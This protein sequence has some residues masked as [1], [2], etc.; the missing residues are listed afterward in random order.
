MKKTLKTDLSPSQ[1]SE[2]LQAIS[3]PARSVLQETM[4]LF[5][6]K[7]PYEGE[8]SPVDFRINRR[9]ERNA[10]FE[11]FELIG[12]I[13]P[14]GLG[15]IIEIES[16][17]NKNY[18]SLIPKQWPKFVPILIVVIMLILFA[19]SKEAKGLQQS[20]NGLIMIGIMS[21]VAFIACKLRTPFL[22]SRAQKEIE[23]IRQTLHAHEV[24]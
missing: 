20:K 8:V 24:F 18:N 4:Q 3:D 23:F 22:E 2:K 21:I 13:K 11:A 14:D 10:D 5:S 12:K 1:V 19:V 15:A 6:P 7:K 17:S 9:G 16:Y